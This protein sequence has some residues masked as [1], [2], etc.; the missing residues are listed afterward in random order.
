MRIRIDGCG[1]CDESRRLVIAMA[2]AGVASR[3]AGSLAARMAELSVGEGDA[4]II[5]SRLGEVA[6][7]SE[8]IERLLA[9]D[10]GGEIRL[11]AFVARFLQLRMMVAGADVWGSAPSTCPSISSS[12]ASSPTSSAT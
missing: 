4:C 2:S 5:V 1:D 3:R 12:H 9:S 8:T 6:R 10:P 7:A 11:G